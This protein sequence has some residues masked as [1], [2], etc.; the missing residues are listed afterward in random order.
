MGESDR[1]VVF[2][3]EASRRQRRGAKEQEHS[4]TT[5]ALLYAELT[6]RLFLKVNLHPPGARLR[7]EAACRYLLVQSHQ[8]NI[9][10]YSGEISSTMRD[11]ATYRRRELR[12]QD[13]ITV[14]LVDVCAKMA[15]SRL[16][17]SGCI[18][19]FVCGK[20][21]AWRNAFALLRKVL[22]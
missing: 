9:P 11:D 20:L 18:R 22:L 7:E 6:T 16:R 17:I 15:T 14:V 3:R 12:K 1:A 5:P 2:P 21:H 13:G 8:I 19:L 10:F 4:D